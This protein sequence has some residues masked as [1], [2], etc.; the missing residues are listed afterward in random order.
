VKPSPDSKTPQKNS[1]NSSVAM[2]CY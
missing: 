2:V 1:R